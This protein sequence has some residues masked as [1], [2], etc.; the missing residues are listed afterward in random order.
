MTESDPVRPD[1]VEPAASPSQAGDEFRR[2]HPIS[3]VLSAVG[4]APR[5]LLAAGLVVFTTG[6]GRVILAVAA[7][8]LVV[9]ILQYWRTTYC[10]TEERLVVRSGWFQR[11]ERVVSPDRLQHVEVVRAVRHR[12][13][14]VAQVTVSLA[15]STSVILDSVSLDEAERLHATLE[16]GRRL[17]RA[18]VVSND[19]PPPP[20][21]ELLTLGLGELALGAV[22][23]AGLLLFPAVGFAIVNQVGD[24]VG[25]RVDADRVVRL[26]VPI[27]A[28]G[29]LVAAFVVAIGV[30]W[31]RYFGYA[32][33]RSGVDVAVEYGLLDRRSAVIPLRRVQRSSARANIVRR[34]VGLESIDVSLA[35]SLDTY[36]SGS[37]DDTVPVARST[38]ARRLLA[39][40]SDLEAVPVPDVSHPPAARRRAAIRRVG[41]LSPIWIAGIWLEWWAGLVG[42]VATGAVAWFWADRWWRRLRHAASGQVVVIDEGVVIWTRTVQPWSKVQSVST[43]QSPAQR[44]SGLVDL[45]LQ[46]A[47]S[48]STTRIRDLGLEQAA[49]L[50]AAA[51][52]LGQTCPSVGSISST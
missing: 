22:S 26:G 3:P 40:F 42:L 50:M 39:V 41:G 11:S 33:R 13:V 9:R 5:F 34:W 17:G 43:H 25:D 38:D 45:R 10:L 4:G 27:L 37:V 47:G 7:A 6:L 18:S 14:G 31:V 2:L 16:R 48:P 1:P 28:L 12:L 8:A 15:G 49:G 30:M 51:G 21:A 20:A 24:V 46:V 32:L 44:R 36:G 35:Q 23:G 19:I 29:A 52:Q